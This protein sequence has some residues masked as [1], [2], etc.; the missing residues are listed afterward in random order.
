MG[1][2][3]LHLCMQNQAETPQIYDSFE[4]FYVTLHVTRVTLYRSFHDG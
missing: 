1:R 4:G 3:R 2:F